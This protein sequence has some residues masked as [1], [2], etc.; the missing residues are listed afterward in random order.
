MIDTGPDGFRELTLGTFNIERFGYDRGRAH[1]RLPEALDWLLEQTPVPPDILALPEATRGL[2]DGQYA[3]RRLAVRRLAPH[4]GGG[5]Y[6]PLF[7]SRPLPGRRNHLHLLLV[8]TAKVW[9][10]AWHDPGRVEQGRHY[11]GFAECEIFG[12]EV[13]L[14]CEHW[15]G[16]EGREAFERAAHR[17]STW[18][19]RKT[20]LL[21]DFNADSGWEGEL[22][23][24]TVNW[25]EQCRAQDNLHK[26]WQKGW[27]DPSTGRWGID[28]R[29]MDMLR[30]EFGYRDLGEQFGDATPTTNP[31]VGRGLRIDRLLRSRHLPM[32]VL[33]YRVFQPP[34]SVSDHGY[35]HARTS[36]PVLRPGGGTEPPDLD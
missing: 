19:R 23:H 21:G 8:N 15:S 28:T 11:D 17:V 34:R 32:E 29:Q 20:L 24:S 14:C 13:N 35:V 16:G 31:R 26:L 18:G 1:H 3:I 5:W 22:H 6:E 10:L 36:V 12:H 4:L 27:R 2:D 30:T 33:E 25:Y 7:S 9:P